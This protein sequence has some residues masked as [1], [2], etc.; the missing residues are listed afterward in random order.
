LTD[1]V[2]RLAPPA[3]FSGTP[4]SSPFTVLKLDEFTFQHV[5]SPS[6]NLYVPACESTAEWDDL[7]EDDMID[8]CWNFEAAILVDGRRSCIFHVQCTWHPYQSSLFCNPHYDMVLQYWQLMESQMSFASQRAFEQTLY[9]S[10][11][12]YLAELRFQ[13]GVEWIRLVASVLETVRLVHQINRKYKVWTIDDE[14]GTVRG[15]RGCPYV[16]SI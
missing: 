3:I 12:M 14:F 1:E 16:L 4:P 2:I 9:S 13:T 11:A 6:H 7:D 15:A 8:E 5:A 10:D